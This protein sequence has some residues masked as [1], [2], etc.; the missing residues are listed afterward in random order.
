[1]SLALWP[2]F[3]PQFP[4]TGFKALGEVLF[5]EIEVLNEIALDH[6]L[7]PLTTFA[8]NR[9]VPEDFDGSPDDVEKLLGEWGEWFEPRHGAD[10]FEALSVVL[11]DNETARRLHVPDQVREEL[12]E[13]VRLLRAAENAHVRFRLELF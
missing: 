5:G 10:A 4:T 9:E 3:D 2:V 13:Y 6:D 12:R 8:D 11:Q 7:V 1:M